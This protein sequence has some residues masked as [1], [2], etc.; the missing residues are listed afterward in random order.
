MATP[1]GFKMDSCESG[2]SDLPPTR[3]KTTYKLILKVL[4]EIAYDG[5]WCSNPCSYY[6]GFEV[7]DIQ[8]AMDECVENW[9]SEDYDIPEFALFATKGIRNGLEYDVLSAEYEKWAWRFFVEGLFEEDDEGDKWNAIFRD[10][11]KEYA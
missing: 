7:K 6:S 2:H 1:Q 3:M 11:Q 5:V 9:A 10:M 8:S 4:L